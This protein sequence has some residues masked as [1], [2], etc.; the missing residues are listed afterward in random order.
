MGE[1]K[2]RAA[3][4]ATGGDWTS[5]RF[6]SGTCLHCGAPFTGLTGPAEQPTM[7]A[8]MVCGDC[9]YVTEWDGE[10]HVEL[11]ETTMAEAS[12]NPEYAKL[13]AV[14]RALR[15]LP[16]MPQRII[17]L[18]PR[19]PEIC[20]DCGKLDELRPYGHK[21]ADGKR[22]WVCFPCAHKDEAELNRAFDERI[23]GENPV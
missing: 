22:K 21:K 19:E 16:R 13:L 15:A 12:A 4:G 9:G 8:L 11:S 20:E 1:K 23:E 17:M 7:G 10:K 14:T 5:V 3:A 18:E 2:R 6:N